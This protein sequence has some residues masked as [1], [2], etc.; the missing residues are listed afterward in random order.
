M[1]K[2]K[3]KIAKIICNWEERTSYD[4][5]KVN[6]YVSEEFVW[7][8]KTIDKEQNE[9]YNADNERTKCSKGGAK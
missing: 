9:V 2:P 8:K 4:T 3:K 1:Y 7:G 6:D 5:T